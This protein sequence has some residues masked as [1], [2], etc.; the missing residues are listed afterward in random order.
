M[1]SHTALEFLMGSDRDDEAATVPAW[2]L[3]FQKL[4]DL[5]LHTLSPGPR[6]ISLSTVIN[7]QKV[8]TFAFVGACMWLYGHYH[9]AAWV[10][11]ALHGSYGF[12]WLMKELAFP[13]ASFREQISALGAVHAFALV[14][15]PYW[16]AGWL[17]VSNPHA[18]AYPLLS[19]PAWYCMC[20]CMCVL[21]VAVMIAADAQKYFSL[22]LRPGV[23]IT[24]GMFALVRH[25]N[26]AGEMLIYGSF[27]L[28]AWHV[29]PALVLVWVWTALFARNMVFKEKRMSRHTAWAAYRRRTWWLVPFVL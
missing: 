3:F 24:D 15:G 16:L 7:F 5:F 27:A 19:E 9:A 4:N 21:G 26:Y 17:V 18:P 25:P 10:Y 12:V 11:L 6:N 28:L 8:C 14:L 23:L 29:V 22:R 2:A 20:I 13:D 1:Q